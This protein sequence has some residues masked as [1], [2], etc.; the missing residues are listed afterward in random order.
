MS[1]FIDLTG[2][3]FGNLVVEELDRK[4]VKPGISEFYWKCVCDCGTTKTIPGRALKSENGTRS[5]GCSR[6]KPLTH[7]YCTVRKS[8]EFR[9]HRVWSQMIQRCRN[10]NSSSY[11]YYGGRGIN[12]CERWQGEDG[13]ANFIEDMG[14]RP[15]GRLLERK[16]NDGDYTPENC[17]WATK[18]EQ[19]RNTHQNVVIE[20]EGRSQ[21]LK[22]WAEELDLPY[23]PLYL[24]IRKNGW[25]IERAFTTP[26]RK[27]SRKGQ[28]HNIK[29]QGQTMSITEWATEID[30]SAAVISRRLVLGWSI[31]RILTTPVRKRKSR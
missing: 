2:K 30:I 4:D 10:P 18:A 11:R 21:C 22:A 9:V 19:A 14:P 31:K 5:C 29:F 15:E 17:R 16:D 28:K 27:S 6:R 7:G 3:R 13:F 23:Q 8:E 26:I 24:R 20:Y 12:V 25:S 1:R